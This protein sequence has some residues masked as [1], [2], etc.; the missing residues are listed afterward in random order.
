[1][2]FRDN[3]P[4]VQR[5]EEEVAVE[6]KSDEGCLYGNDSSGLDG[7]AF[8]GLGTSSLDDED[9]HNILDSYPR[10]DAVHSDVH[11]CGVPW[12]EQTL[13]VRERRFGAAPSLED[14]YQSE[15]QVQEDRFELQ[16]D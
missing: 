14:I 11:H 4:G 5:R 10:I 9:D 12:E 1:M 3:F 2:V 7:M 6:R 15:S 8:Q 13:V 16:F